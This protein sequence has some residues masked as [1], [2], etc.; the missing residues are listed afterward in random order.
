MANQKLFKYKDLEDYKKLDKSNY[1]IL[2]KKDEVLDFLFQYNKTIFLNIESYKGN[3]FCISICDVV[4]KITTIPIVDANKKLF[5][6]KEE[7]I[8][9]LEEFKIFIKSNVIVLFDLFES[10]EIFRKYNFSLNTFLDIK[11][12]NYI[13]SLPEKPLSL[14]DMKE[15]YLYISYDFVSEFNEKSLKQP[16][17]KIYEK[18]AVKC[19]YVCQIFHK[20]KN[21]PNEKEMDLICGLTYV[22]KILLEKHIE[23][24]EVDGEKIYP[25]FNMEE[26]FSGRITTSKP[27]VQNMKN[28]FVVD[29]G[30]KFLKADLREAEF[31]MFMLMLG[32][33]KTKKLLEKDIFV[34]TSKKLL[35][36]DNRAKGKLLH[37]GVLYGITEYG[38]S[39]KLDISLE[40]AKEVLD[41][42]NKLFSPFIKYRQ[43]VI[44]SA[45][46][47]NSVYNYF[48][49]EY[50]FDKKTN[51]NTIFNTII[52][53]SVADMV[54]LSLKE[55]HKQI[56]EKELDAKFFMDIHDELVFEVVE[57]D[58]EDLKDII[59]EVYSE[60]ELA[61][62]S[63]EVVDEY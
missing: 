20:I 38:L 58:V 22:K 15:K 54:H 47:G 49:R 13:L 60:Y 63:F 36:E 4:G 33:E 25:N 30:K 44:D 21:N 34:L 29:E 56:K 16:M 50:N 51:G 43:R 57:E 26:N 6:S 48:G 11:L 5:F 10:R 41:N 40:K 27:N 37:Y 9:I 17:T 8:E 52:K 2:K 46:E 31:R 61:K 35:N 62:V 12:I 55:I 53:S 59:S 19:D 3:L 14:N 32:S 18:S 42:Y 39:K 1:K 28:V 23:G 7:T 45:L 24:I